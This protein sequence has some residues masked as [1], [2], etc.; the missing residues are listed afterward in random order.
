M[1]KLKLTYGRSEMTS[2]RQTCSE[3]RQSGGPTQDGVFLTL[4]QITEL[5]RNTQTTADPPPRTDFT[6]MCSDYSHLGGRP[7][8]GSEGV[9]EVQA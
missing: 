7:F 6:R 2:R 9:I 4:N 3:T 1:A 5:V 8:K